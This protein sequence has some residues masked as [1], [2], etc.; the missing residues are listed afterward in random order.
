MVVRAPSRAAIRETDKPPVPLVLPVATPEEH[1]AA[2][3]HE[4][5]IS[6]GVASGNTK[7]GNT[8]SGNTKNP[9]PEEEQTE[10]RL[11]VHE[12]QAQAR[13]DVHDLAPC[14]R[15]PGLHKVIR[16]EMGLVYLGCGCEAVT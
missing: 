4:Q 9:P 6:G 11:D 5:G 8:K 16:H 2:N 7:G 14:P 12:G 13:L 10:E 15:H 1:P 3:P